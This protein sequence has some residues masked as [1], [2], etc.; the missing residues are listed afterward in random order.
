MSN[1]YN[2]LGVDKKA[3]QEEIKKAFW[4]QAK[5][6]HPDRGGDKDK[7]AKLSHAY[8]ILSNKGKR[9]RYDKT[10]EDKETPFMTK[11]AMYINERFIQIIDN[12]KNVGTFDLIGA[13]KTHTET[14]ISG[15]HNTQVEF[16]QKLSKYEGVRRRT[17]SSGDTLILSVL[18]DSIKDIKATIDA[19][20]EDIEFM[21]KVIEVLNHYKYDFEEMQR[22][23]SFTFGGGDNATGNTIMFNT[24]SNNL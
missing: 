11:F 21:N 9:D 5:E 14:T 4:E 18:D 17:S 13:F 23:A 7:M 22:P 3:S 16:K 1:L 10:G 24:Y 2:D 12:A 6:H 8:N 19:L 20:D 15:L